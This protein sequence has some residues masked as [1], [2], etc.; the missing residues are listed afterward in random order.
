MSKDKSG[1]QLAVQR[2][3]AYEHESFEK[4]I[5]HLKDGRLKAGRY[6]KLLKLKGD[7]KR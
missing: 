6:A 1:D 5:L 4:L 3:K 2:Y 7:G